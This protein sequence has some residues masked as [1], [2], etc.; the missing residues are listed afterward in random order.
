MRFGISCGAAIL[1]AHRR[2]GPI[3]QIDHRCETIRRN[4]TEN[5]AAANKKE[6]NMLIHVIRFLR[7]WRLAADNLVE[8]SSKSDTELRDMGLTRADIP[9]V[10]LERTLAA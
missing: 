3:L 10:A 1:V 4:L 6:L 9:R 8:L 2:N 7:N 5:S